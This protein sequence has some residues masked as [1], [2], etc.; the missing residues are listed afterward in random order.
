MMPGEFI[1]SPRAPRRLSRCLF[2]AAAD[3]YEPLIAP[4]AAR[5]MPESRAGYDP[6]AASALA[7]VSFQALS[8]ADHLSGWQRRT[9]M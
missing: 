3:K 4:I 2:N 9:A 6:G 8:V 7:A 5:A 1:P